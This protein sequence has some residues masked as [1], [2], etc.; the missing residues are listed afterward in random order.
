MKRDPRDVSDI[1]RRIEPAL[2]VR[3]AAGGVGLGYF[4]IWLG[5]LW[6]LLGGK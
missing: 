2:P 1:F 3:G 6:L 4:L 5:I